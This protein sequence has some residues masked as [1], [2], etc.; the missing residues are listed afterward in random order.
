MIP[1]PLEA[2]AE[3]LADE[4]IPTGYL[5]HLHV[6]PYGSPTGQLSVHWRACSFWQPSERWRS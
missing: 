2:I 6:L 5:G 1:L 3:L 4:V